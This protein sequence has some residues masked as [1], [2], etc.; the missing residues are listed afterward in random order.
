MTIAW[1][2]CYRRKSACVDRPVGIE[3][4]VQLRGALAGG[5]LELVERFGGD[6]QSA[7]GQSNAGK[8]LLVHRLDDHPGGD[9]ETTSSLCR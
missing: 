4:G 8:L 3:A 5:Y 9:A 7:V 6:S 2:V 1:R